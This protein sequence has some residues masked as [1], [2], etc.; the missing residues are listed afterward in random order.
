MDG[1]ALEIYGENGGG[2]YMRLSTGLRSDS[3]EHHDGVGNRVHR[4]TICRSRRKACAN[5]PEPLI[6]RHRTSAALELEVE[7]AAARST[8]VR[9]RNTIGAYDIDKYN[10]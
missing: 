7:V 3:R 1:S 4:A 5:P 2:C 9:C 8:Q 6:M 10:I